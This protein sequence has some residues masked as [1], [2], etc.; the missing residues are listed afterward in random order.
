M[1]VGTRSLLFGYHCPIWHTFFV[2]FS[3]WKLYGF[4][5]NPK[6]WIC[7]LLHDIGYWGKPNM[8]GDEGMFHP[9]LGAEVIAKMFGPKWFFFCLFHSRSMV[10]YN[11]KWIKIIRDT[12]I[13]YVEPH[14]SK[15][16][17]A[18]KMAFL[19]TPRF[20]MNKDELAEYMKNEATGNIDNFFNILR[21]KSRQF[22]E[23]NKDKAYGPDDY[24]R[25]N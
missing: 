14:V 9:Y 24:K 4:P 21:M 2:A 25:E 22:I 18:D 5:W 1:R 13:P 15:L 11:L 23:E 17:L 12:T 19:Y 20:L 16:C 3:W 10:E 7:F 6:L 8:D